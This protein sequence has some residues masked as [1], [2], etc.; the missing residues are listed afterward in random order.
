M[1]F[2]ELGNY[3]IQ[4]SISFLTSYVAFQALTHGHLTILCGV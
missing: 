2:R 3:Q 4:A 1:P